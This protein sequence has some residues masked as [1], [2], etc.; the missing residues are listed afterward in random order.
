M[1]ARQD[2]ST[3][4]SDEWMTD[5]EAEALF[6]VS[7]RTIQRWSEQVKGFPRPFYLPPTYTLRRWKR[8]EMEAFRNRFEQHRAP[9]RVRPDELHPD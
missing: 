7:R 8:A 3:A 6:K 5:R 2:K 4:A 9:A 1:T